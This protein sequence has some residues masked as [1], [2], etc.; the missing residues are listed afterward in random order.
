MSQQQELEIF[1]ACTDVSRNA[2]PF[3]VTIGYAVVE[4]DQSDRQ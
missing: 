1:Q 2:T 3:L 4:M